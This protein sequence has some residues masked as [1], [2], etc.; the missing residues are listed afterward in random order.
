MT[1]ITG[2]TGKAITGDIVVLIGQV[3]GVV[4]FVAIHAAEFLE[5]SRRRMTIRAFIPFAAVFAAENGEIRL[6]MLREVAGHPARLGRVAGGAVG[7]E[8]AGL[9]VGAGGGPKIRLVAGKAVGGR[10]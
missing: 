3:A 2:R 4:M 8:V 7:R 6:V 1:R 9:V 5:I 10:I